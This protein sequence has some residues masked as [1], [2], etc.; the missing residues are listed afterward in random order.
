M[1]NQDQELKVRRCD[2]FWKELFIIGEKVKETYQF[3][4]LDGDAQLDCVNRQDRSQR[5][6]L[7]AQYRCSA[8]RCCEEANTTFLGAIVHS[9][10]EEL[11]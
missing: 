6:H 3:L 10:G 4:T 2:G 5:E 1:Q 9:H 7:L 11:F 8:Y